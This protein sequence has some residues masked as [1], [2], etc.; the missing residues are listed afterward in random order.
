MLTRSTDG[1]F[2]TM[3]GYGIAPGTG[4]VNGTTSAEVNRV[5]GRVDLSSGTIDTTTALTDTFSGV[6]IRGAA[7]TNGTD[8]WLAGAN[9]GV[10]YATLGATTST[11]ITP[12]SGAP[13][14]TRVVNIFNDQLYVSAMS[15]AFRGVSTVGSTPPPTTPDNPITL[16]AGFDPS[17]TSPQ[18]TYDFW[19]K[20]AN[21]LY[22]ADDRS[23]ASGG[24]IQKWT[25]DAGPMTW[26]LAYTLNVNSGA[27]GLAGT[28]NGA[29]EAVLY[30]TT[31]DNPSRLA[32]ITDTGMDAVFATLATAGAN[33]QFR[34]VEF[35]GGTV[36]PPANN[37][38]FDNDG[39]VDG[40]DFL[41]W[42]AN[43]GATGVAPGNKSTGD[44]NG[45]GNVDAADLGIWQAHFGLPPSIGAAGAVPEP[46]AWALAALGLA[47]AGAARRR[48]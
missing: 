40:A 4:G 22:V 5:V 37:S 13:T 33:T 20:D 21:T 46:G 36:N 2:L 47:A 3:G 26:S 42:Q 8:I 45:D 30:A 29:G 41:T 18:S 32:T 10:R 11:A 34:G 9:G 23:V 17:T 6:S 44:A 24:G 12:S 1:N 25:L 48:A 35:V 27:R 43:L 39:D 38:D 15:G 14:N 31:A 7:S 16:L 28:T 19:F